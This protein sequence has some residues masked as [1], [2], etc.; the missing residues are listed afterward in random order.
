MNQLI[1]AFTGISSVG[2][3]S[4]LRQ[5]AKKIDFQHITGGT[6]IATARGAASDARDSIRHADLDENQRLLIKGFA[7]TRDSNA[8]LIVMDGHVIIDNGEELTTISSE[9][10]KALGVSVMV[11]LEAEPERIAANREGDK[12][13][14]RPAYPFHILERHQALSRTHAQAIAALLCAR[15]YIVTH[16]DT[17]RLAQLLIS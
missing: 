1:V 13:R 8:N 12:L 17:D 15:F 11:H 3:T 6:L 5:L 10:F 4:F 14:R 9:V 16:N 2:K 7:L